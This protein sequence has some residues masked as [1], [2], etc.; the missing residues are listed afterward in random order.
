MPVIPEGIYNTVSTKD[1]W[2]GPGAAT[3]PCL[4]KAETRYLRLQLKSGGRWDLLGSCNGTTPDF[5][6]ATDD[7]SASGTYTATDDTLLLVE[8]GTPPTYVTLGWGLKDDVLTLRLMD[9]TPPDPEAGG[10]AFAS[11]WKLATPGPLSALSQPASVNSVFPMH[12]SADLPAGVSAADLASG[13]AVWRNDVAG[14]VRWWVGAWLVANAYADSCQGTMVSPKVGPSVD[15][16]TT[17][18]TNMVGIQAGPV[19]DVT[20][21]GFHGKTFELDPSVP[22]SGCAGDGFLNEWIPPIG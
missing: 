5:S 1:D 11:D 18:L 3:D 20:I 21:G 14:P 17:A 7:W 15:D 10:P 8:P 19:S 22:T 16:L 2:T 9:V 13:Y 12:V 6:Y 4:P